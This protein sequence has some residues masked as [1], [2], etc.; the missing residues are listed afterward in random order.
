MRKLL[1]IM[2]TAT[3]AAAV[4]LLGATPASAGTVTVEYHCAAGGG[5]VA[6]DVSYKTTITAPATIAQ[7]QTATVKIEYTSVKATTVDHPAGR[8]NGWASFKLGGVQTGTVIADGLTNPEIKAGEKMRFINASAPVTFT[9][10][11]T[12]TFTPSSFHYG[13]ICNVW[14]TPAGVA[15]STTVV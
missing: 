15:A 11:G 2:A 4:L 7:G 10:K 1:S 5:I 8:A 13:P 12:V 6:W 14:T 9:S 3:T